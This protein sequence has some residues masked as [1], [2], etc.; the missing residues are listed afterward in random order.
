MGCVGA[1]NGGPCS[2]FLFSV[3]RP[4]G[5]LQNSFCK[6]RMIQYYCLGGHCGI[7]SADWVQFGS[8]C[9]FIRVCYKKKGK[10]KE[11]HGKRLRFR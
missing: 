1:G 6:L 7:R 4:L 9:V 10:E 5:T 8:L 2:S 11:K 3:K